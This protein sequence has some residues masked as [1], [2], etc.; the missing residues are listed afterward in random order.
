MIEDDMSGYVTSIL[1]DPKKMNPVEVG[2]NL[3]LNQHEQ[4][5]IRYFQM[6]TNP[7]IEFFRDIILENLQNDNIH[8]SSTLVIDQT[9][10]E[11]TEIM[12]AIR[13]KIE[14]ENRKVIIRIADEGYVLTRED[15]NKLAFAST[16]VVDHCIPELEGD[17]R[18]FLQK[19]VFKFDLQMNQPV[20]ERRKTFDELETR[21]SF[22][23]NH[24]LS[25]EEFETLAAYV[26]D[27]EDTSIEFNVFDPNYYEE[28][29]QG[30][31]RHH[32][33]EGLNIQFIGYL[34]QDQ[35]D[36]YRKLEKYPYEIDI[37]YSTCHDMVENYTKE[38]YC[39]N[40]LYY[41]QIEGGGKT[42]LRNYINVLEEVHSFEQMVQEGNL[43]PLEA[44]VLAK[45]IIDSEY[46]YD[47]DAD[48]ADEWDNIN[49]SQ[50]INHQVNGKKRAV[51]MGFSTLY[52]AL[53][54]RVGIP[55]FRYSTTGH[56]RNL[57]KI[58][59]EKYGVDSISVCDITF[60]LQSSNHNLP[61]YSY[62]MVAPRELTKSTNS[63]GDYEHMTVAD[64]LVLPMEEYYSHVVP[65]NLY[66][67]QF[68]H[69][70][71]Y[72][73]MG[74]AAR[75]L[76]L[77][78]EGPKEGMGIDAYDTIY[79]IVEEGRLEGIPPEVILKAI[80]RV[81]D[82]LGMSPEAKEHYRAMAGGSFMDRKTIFHATPA[83]GGNHQGEKYEVHPLT[84]ENI[85]EY[86]SQLPEERPRY[87][88][89]FQEEVPEE[90]EKTTQPEPPTEP[91]KEPVNPPKTEP[92]KDLQDM[93]EYSE[94]YIPGTNIHRPRVRGIYETDEEYVE[95]LRDFYERHF[96][97]STYIENLLA[98]VKEHQLTVYDY[99]VQVGDAYENQEEVPSFEI[100]NP[101]VTEED[102]K[103][104]VNPED[105]RM[106]LFFASSLTK[107]I[108]KNLSA[109]RQQELQDMLG[110]PVERY[111]EEVGYRL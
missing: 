51:C 16:I 56:S 4:L 20:L 57:G 69:P 21:F 33:R 89:T 9:I 32:V 96:P 77:M 90:Q 50:M 55:M 17:S 28:F 101:F 44:A 48:F 85:Q 78:G 104:L 14:K 53:L 46:I 41:S 19:G 10:L 109:N 23:I 92:K 13:Q 81:T 36:L 72:E 31:Q 38:P 54:R 29:L 2:G 7:N 24:R 34:L 59:D 103:M 49:L 40:R 63:H 18:I 74:Y 98:Y 6:S 84:Q 71:G 25:E 70:I 5:G 8:F 22:H 1:S 66:Y 11:D 76:E 73:P 79:R 99:Y 67:E 37:V 45:I 65:T 110:D 27:G 102:K 60:D 108:E 47:P 62:F 43:S 15:Y 95:F 35:I 88:Q 106:S 42:S 82:F 93:F 111:N 97:G 91:R 107:V 61:T 80:D 39:E 100:D 26:N 58:Q 12:E 86:R 94:E 64:A 68:Y 105:P 52:S 30:L 3:R 83:I 87:Y 75:M